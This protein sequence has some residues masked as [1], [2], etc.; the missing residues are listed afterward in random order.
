MTENAEPVQ[1]ITTYGPTYAA[2]L[3][4]L[5][6]PQ[7]IDRYAR[8]YHRAANQPNNAELDAQCAMLKLAIADA[9]TS[10]G[11]SEAMRCWATS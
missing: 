6:L 7:L 9:I 2:E 10:P 4:R 5:T 11:L 8:T 1:Q 3:G